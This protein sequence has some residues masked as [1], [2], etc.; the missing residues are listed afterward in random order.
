MRF[1]CTVLGGV[2]FVA[3][4]CTEAGQGPD[5]GSTNQSDSSSAY[6]GGQPLDDAGNP[7]G[8]AGGTGDGGPKSDG[9][10]TGGPETIPLAQ[11]LADGTCS[12]KPGDATLG[13]GFANAS[14]IA[15]IVPMGL[16]T[17]AHITPVDHMYVYYPSQQ[18]RT[19]TD[20][21]VVS[22]A[23][24]YVRGVSKLDSDYRVIIEHSCDV[25]SIFI[26]VQTL[27]GPLASLNSQVT[28]QKGWSGSIA[29]K[30]GEAFATDGGQPGYDY[31]LHDMRTTLKGLRPASYA[32][33]ETWKLHV[34]DPFD[35]TP[36]PIKTQLLA[37]DLRGVAPRGGKIDYDTAGVATGNWF[38]VG[39]NG[40]AGDPKNN[41]TGPISPTQMRGY[42]D[43]HLALAPHPVDPTHFIASVG[44]Y[45]GNAVQYATEVDPATLTAS[46]IPT[47]LKL[48]SFE[49]QKADG[50]PF[51]QDANQA[52]YSA[53]VKVKL[54]TQMVGVLLVQLQ[55]D[56]TL[57]VEKRPGATASTSTTFG[58]DVL[59]YEH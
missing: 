31:S 49:L 52:A 34:V 44:N 22:P 14:E 59:T 17:G 50:T 33:T 13:A 46:S 57:K 2:G 43:T 25:W 45:G 51:T 55:A 21:P 56:G 16:M 53:G 20:Y 11:I 54:G 47:A 27:S 15:Y 29:I 30:E 10:G 12:S 32:Q 36:D 39:T 6:D 5:G 3:V 35:Y 7:G 26:H 23:G 41:T 19:L 37:K 48:Y 40:Y 28:Y 8:D 1:L 9:G 42:W 24:G 18:P 4:A 38:V 58:T